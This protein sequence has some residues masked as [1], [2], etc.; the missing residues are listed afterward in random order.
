MGVRCE[1]TLGWSFMGIIH[2]GTDVTRDDRMEDETRAKAFRE[3]RRK[4][5]IRADGI[6]GE[7]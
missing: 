4:T 7:G 5:R 1:A 2:M 6:D 3:P